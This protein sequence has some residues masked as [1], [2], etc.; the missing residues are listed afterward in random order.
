MFN[1][2]L[3]NPFPQQLYYSASSA[4]SESS[5]CFVSSPALRDISTFYL[6]HSDR[7]IVCA[8]VL[9]HVWLLASLWT[10]AF[11]TPLSI[12]FSRQK[13]WNGL[14]VPPPGDLPD[15][16][17]KLQ[18]PASLILAGRFFT[19]EPLGKPLVYNGSFLNSLFYFFLGKLSRSIGHPSSKKKFFHS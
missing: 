11:Q 3:S 1:Y 13:Y 17:I 2:K 12:G 7:Y 18:S 5:S 10:V 14:P 19:S 6:N 16:G 8:C 4:M 15:P 9:S